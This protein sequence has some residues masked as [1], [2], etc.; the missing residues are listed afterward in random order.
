[1]FFFK[2]LRKLL[3]L[4]TPKTKVAGPLSSLPGEQELNVCEKREKL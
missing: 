1:M 4:T 3:E 2:F